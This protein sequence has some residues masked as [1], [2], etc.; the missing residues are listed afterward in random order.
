[1]I[2]SKLFI[3]LLVVNS[4]VFSQIE[5][6]TEKFI[7]PSILEENSGIIFYGNKLI[8]H[9]DSG[10]Q[11]NLYELD[12]IT[13]QITRTIS[14]TNASNTD[15]EDITQDNDYIYIGDFGNNLG[16]RTDLKVYKI[17]KTDYLVNNTVSATIINFSYEDQTDFSNNSETN[18][19]A[20]AM[21]V[22]NN[23]IHVFTKNRGDFK[24]KQYTIPNTAGTHSATLLNTYNV[25][26]L[27]TG[28]SLNPAYNTVLLL[29]YTS[30]LK[31]FIVQLDDMNTNISFDSFEK[32]DLFPEIGYNQT[33]GIC[34]TSDNH[35]FIS[36]ERFV[37]NSTTINQKL[38]TFDY[39]PSV[40]SIKDNVKF[41]FLVSPNPLKN[42]LS[43]N[44]LP[45]NSNIFIY[46]SN[47]I[48]VFSENTKSTSFN[49]HRK[50]NISNGVYFIKVV[51]TKNSITKKIIL[52]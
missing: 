47:G 48:L 16:M 49:W 8:T 5:N 44:N 33:E 52:K 17:A 31:P 4:T 7:L 36:S 32:T 23:N 20:E 22:Y 21:I 25:E 45:L 10:E 12:T 50:N 29:G 39:T 43:I 6:L 19:D 35:F 26:G 37:Y 3:L 30:Y 14:I 27:I 1:M 24:T 34:L 41:N 28:A 40:N 46:N 13:N 9:N 11:A 15:W 42:E 51:N 2:K 38:F 18:F